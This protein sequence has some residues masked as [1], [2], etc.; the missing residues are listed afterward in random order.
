MSDIIFLDVDGTLVHHNDDLHPQNKIALKKFQ[1][2]GNLVSLCTGRNPADVKPFLYQYN[3]PFDYLI[4]C[5]GG[6]ILDAKGNTV[7]AKYIAKEIGDQLVLEYAYNNDVV[8]YACNQDMLLVVNQGVISTVDEHGLKDLDMTIDEFISSSK[9]YYMLSLNTVDLDEDKIKAYAKKIEEQYGD[10]LACHL[11]TVYL[12]I[13]PP[14]LSKGTGVQELLKLVN[15]DK[16]YAI[17]DANN[18][19]SML[20]VVDEPYT[21]DYA[22]KEV[23]A[24]AKHIVSYVYEIFE[25]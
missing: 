14:F 3:F 12:D 15:V 16:S 10:T 9:F 11:N 23:Q 2:A 8:L 22:N 19:L 17:G 20:K 1:E 7:Y 13:V 24:V 5:N 6:C 4:L 21:F 25:K 18:D